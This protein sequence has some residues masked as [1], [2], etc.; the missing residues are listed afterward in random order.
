MT[1]LVETIQKEIDN[2]RKGDY[3]NID[4]SVNQ[5]VNAN[6]FSKEDYKDFYFNQ[7][8]AWVEGGYMVD[9]SEVEDDNIVISYYND[10][11]LEES[12]IVGNFDYIE[13]EQIAL[14]RLAL[15]EKM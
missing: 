6:V 5:I 4:G 15:N 9:P 12:F 1:K 14:N 8:D 7:K 2:H 3:L 11:G 10:S 13:S